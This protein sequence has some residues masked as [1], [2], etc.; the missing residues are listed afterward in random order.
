MTR[1]RGL[2]HNHNHMLKYVFKGAATT[3]LQLQTKDEPLRRAY[4]R[5]LT[6]GTN[7]N[8]AK[9]SLARKLAAIT[10]ALWKKKE[11]YDPARLMK[12]A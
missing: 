12:T 10:L 3:V 4:E 7:P 9:V 6:A 8:L 1:T 2:N 11:V 5:M